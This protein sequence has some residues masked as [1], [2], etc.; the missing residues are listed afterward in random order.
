MSQDQPSQGPVR[1]PRGHE[2]RPRTARR[3]ARDRYRK[4]AK[5][6]RRAGKP[7]GISFKK[8]WAKEK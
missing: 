2:G 1:G 5:A 3:Q 4:I 8:W 7:L 6:A